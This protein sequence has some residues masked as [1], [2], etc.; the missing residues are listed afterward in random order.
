V[1]SIRNK[2]TN[3]VDIID[4][5]EIPVWLN[6][7]AM[8]IIREGMRRVV[9]EPGGTGSMA[10][11]SGIV[12]AGKTGTAENPHGAAHAWYVGFAPFDHPKIAIAVM[13][14]NAGYGGTKAAPIARMVM[15]KYLFGELR[16]K[17][18]TRVSATTP[19]D[20]IMHTIERGK[21]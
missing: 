14:E 18:S 8:R 6:G 11:I 20:T 2:R 21:H 10:R 4:H 12:S 16:R 19:H 13:L 5:S 17:V 3:K 7:D 9:E 1:S 15:E